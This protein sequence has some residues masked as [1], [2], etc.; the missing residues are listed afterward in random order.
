MG[1]FEVNM[2][3]EQSMVMQF[4]SLLVRFGLLHSIIPFLNDKG[5]NLTTMAT[6]LHFIISCEHLKNFKVYK[7]TCFG[8]VIS[9]AY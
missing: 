1:L 5:I 4:C 9:K 7:G 2:K 3:I 6:T 8:H